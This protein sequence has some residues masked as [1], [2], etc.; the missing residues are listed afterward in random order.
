MKLRGVMRCLLAA[1]LISCGGGG[2]DGGSGGPLPCIASVQPGPVP[3]DVGGP[4]GA[5]GVGDGGGSAGAGSVGGAEGQFKRALIRVDQADGRFVGESE[6]D[7]TYGMVKMELCS[8]TGPV[9]F[10]LRGRADGTTRYFDEGKGTELPFPANEQMHAVIARYEK[11]VGITPLTEAAWQY[12]VARYGADGWKTVARVNEANE[13]IR[14]EFNR[15]LPVGMQIEDITRLPAI[16]GPATAAGSL[17]AT[18]NGLYGTVVSGLAQSAALFNVGEITPALTIA[19]QIGRDLSDG[20]L[21]LFYCING[22]PANCQPAPVLDGQ[23]QAPSRSTYGPAQFSE[24]VNTGISQVSRRFGSSANQG[25]ALQ[26]TQIKI[27]SF[28]SSGGAGYSDTSPIFLL[29]NDGNLYFWPR[30]SQP[31]LPYDTGYRQMYGNST[32]LGSKLDGRVLRDPTITYPPPSDPNGVA[33]VAFPPAEAPDYFGATRIA[34]TAQTFSSSF[35]QIVRKQDARAY[36]DTRATSTGGVLG[37]AVLDNVIDVAVARG[38]A[39]AGSYYA[40]TATGSVYAWGWNGTNSTLGL[41]RSDETLPGPTLNTRLSNIVS[42][43]GC[44]L[45]GFAL[46]RSGRVWGWGFGTVECASVASRVPVLVD[47]INA[48]GRIGQLQ[49]ASFWGCLA[50]TEAGEVIAW[51]YFRDAV[52]SAT[53]PTPPIRLTLPAGRRGIYVGA[54]GLFVYGLLDDGKVMV[55][56]SRPETPTFIDTATVPIK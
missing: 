11:N 15:H 40:S 13:A 9:K 36:V 18:R 32:M 55:F 10:T 33:T 7:D 1:L 25:A 38:G 29:R 6:V 49:C 4:G 17:P 50:L 34:G 24:M 3:S 8:Y 47:S 43:T 23:F 30:R 51:G 28:G 42:V 53:Y 12:L 44:I 41:D 20:R 54:T 26:F 21:D 56:T 22:D 45:G 52:T 16:V 2:G 46:D 37:P 39:G 31:I 5:S 14:A 48:F 27:F 35:N 19:R